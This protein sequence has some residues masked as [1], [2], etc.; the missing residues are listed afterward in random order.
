M[1]CSQNAQDSSLH[2]EYYGM[3]SRI[4]FGNH[5]IFFPK[6]N[7]VHDYHK[8]LRKI[9]GLEALTENY[10]QRC[11]RKYRKSDCYN[12]CIQTKEFDKI[13]FFIQLLHFLL[14]IYSNIFF[15]SS[16]RSKENTEN[17]QKVLHECQS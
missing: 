1:S 10:P 4:T 17:F 2:S 7:S 11:S 13:K 15:S 16:S 5:S 9:C 3:R 12:F 8:T 6:S 14:A